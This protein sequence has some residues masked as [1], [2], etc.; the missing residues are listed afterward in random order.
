MKIRTLFPA[1]LGLLVLAGQSFAADP[2]PLARRVEAF[3]EASNQ[4]DVDAML[5]ATT[6]T[7]RWLQIDNDRIH[8]EVAGH[9]DLRSWL[10]S[11]FGS[12][13]DARSEIGPVQVDGDYASTFE[14][15]RWGGKAQ[16]ALSV[17]RF[18]ADGRIEAVWY[19]PSETRDLS[20]APVTAPVSG[21]G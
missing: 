16:T 4:R 11:Y 9:T 13:P 18:D 7:F 3:V 5:A 20:A 17:Y 14:T 1:T 8:V 12:T 19:F 10:E 2:D 15:T 6:D 21:G